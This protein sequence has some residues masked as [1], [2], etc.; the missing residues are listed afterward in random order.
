VLWGVGEGEPELVGG[1]EALVRFEQGDQLAEDLAD[2]AA[3]D[4]VDDEDEL[5]WCGR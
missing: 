4:L 2:V 1:A 5:V 3:V